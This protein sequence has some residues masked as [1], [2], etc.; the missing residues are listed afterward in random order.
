[1]SVRTPHGNAAR[2]R[3]ESGQTTRRLTVWQ[4]V[5]LTLRALMEA[6]IVVAFGWWGFDTGGGPVAKV[7]LALA[8]PLAAFAL[9]EAVDFRATGR[10]AEALRLVEELVI[11]G[12][13]ALAW[14]ASGQRT[15]GL[16]L[17]GLSILYH[18]L[19]YATGERLLKPESDTWPID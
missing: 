5:N 8:T 4:R 19:V 7:F 1:M 14:Y 11:S 2:E 9:W 3:A 16:A 18:A 12:L 6:G 13:A 10:V 15:L 17:A